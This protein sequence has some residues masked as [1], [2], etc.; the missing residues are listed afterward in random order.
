MVHDTQQRYGAI[1]RFFHWLTAVLI[2]NQLFKFGDY[3]NDGKHWLGD[4]F[5]AY[6]SSIGAV[7]MVLVVLRL[8]WTNKQKGQRPVTPGVLGKI[9]KA[10][11]HTM[12][13]CVF[14]LPP[15]GVLYIYGKGYPVKFF[16][17]TMLDKPE[18]PTPWMA[19]V[20]DL[21]AI[22]A[23][24]LTALVLGHLAGALYHHFV[25]RDETLKR[26]L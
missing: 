21:H 9:A 24:L 10:T 2:I 17:M 19:S 4:T 5:G 6:H 20:G 7:V 22:L 26:M 25:R 14:L 18:S 11:H 23:W 1:T 12:Y 16:G 15:L 8:L 3:F 13:L